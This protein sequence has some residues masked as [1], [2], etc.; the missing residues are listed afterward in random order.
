MMGLTPAS[1]DSTP[2]AY[3][4]LAVVSAARLPYFKIYGKSLGDGIDDIHV[5]IPKAKVTDTIE[6][7]LKNGEF[8]VTSCSGIG[9]A[10][11]NGHCLILVQD[12]TAQS[13]PLT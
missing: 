4:T 7:E 9:V 6:G 11:A 10:D 1:S 12:E 3:Y 13:L 2:S 8:L 5:K